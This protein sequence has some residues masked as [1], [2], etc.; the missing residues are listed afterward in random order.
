M[1]DRIKVLIAD[2]NETFALQLAA[3]F[4]NAP[5]FELVGVTFDGEKTVDLLRSVQPDVLILDLLLPKLDGISVLQAAQTLSKPPL[6]LALTGFL[7]EYTAQAAEQYGVRYFMRKP[8]VPKAVAERAADIVKA[9]RLAQKPNFPSGNV[10]VLATS[11]LCKL[12]VP[13]HVKGYHYLREAILMVVKDP[14]AIGA[15]TKIIYPEVA[16]KFRST[17]TRVE[18]AIRHAIEITWERGDTELLRKFFG[19]SVSSICSKPTNSAFIAL[20]ADRI[21]LQLKTGMSI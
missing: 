18:R 3:C 10:E 5:A 19:C 1:N 7:T 4:K 21:K 16:K 13:A 15:I 11:M 17:S 12:G 14:D 6:G 8:C 2:A 9:E 20:A